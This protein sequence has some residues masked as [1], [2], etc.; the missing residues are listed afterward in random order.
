MKWL[1][2]KKEVPVLTALEGYNL[3]ASTYNNES[4]PIK[5][6]SDNLVEKFLPDLTDK[7][8]LDAG[9]G[10]GK[11]CR[12]A[13]KNKASKIVGIDLSP[14][15]IKEALVNCRS[16]EFI[17]SEISTAPITE[18]HYDVI[19][20]ALVLGHIADLNAALGNLLQGLKCGGSIIITDFHPFL[21]LARSKR[22]FK[23]KSSGKT[24]EVQHYLHMFTDYFECF[25]NYN[26]RIENFEEPLFQKSPVVFGVRAVKS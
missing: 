6:L 14:A 18:S 17:C 15:M 16:A 1:K 22:T 11:F 25:R 8:V 5:N 7:V 19:I 12:L 2:A 21:T 13:E 20:C 3:W 9:C 24:Y 10:T 4:N 26:V 23:D